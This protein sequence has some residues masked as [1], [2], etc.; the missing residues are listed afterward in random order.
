MAMSDWI[1]RYVLA[2]EL[3][4]IQRASFLE[5]IPLLRILHRR[6]TADVRVL[7]SEEGVP[8]GFVVRFKTPYLHLPVEVAKS[9]IGHEGVDGKFCPSAFRFFDWHSWRHIEGGI[10]WIGERRVDIEGEEVAVVAGFV[11]RIHGLCPPLETFGLR[12]AEG[13]EGTASVLWNHAIVRV[14]FEPLYWMFEPEDGGCNV[15]P[16][17]DSELAMLIVS[18]S[19]IGSGN[20]RV[21]DKAVERLAQWISFRLEA[22]GPE[23]AMLEFLRYVRDWGPLGMSPLFAGLKEVL[24]RLRIADKERILFEFYADNWG[25]RNNPY[26]RRLVVKILEAWGTEKALFAL[27]AIA[28]YVKNQVALPEEF[29]LIRGAIDRVTRNRSPAGPERHT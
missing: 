23:K 25:V 10:E 29:D 17:R 21:Y 16:I 24:E 22:K 18:L 2:L 27:Q 11:Y 26:G 5:R 28:A 19:E 9:Q 13:V 3:R 12:L 1:P 4:F 8:G 20:P 6:V 7:G 15:V 14:R